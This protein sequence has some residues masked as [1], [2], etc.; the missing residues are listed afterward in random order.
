MIAEL[1]CIHNN[2]GFIQLYGKD[3]VIQWAELG[4]RTTETY[5][6]LPLLT[7]D[8]WAG[9]AAQDLWRLPSPPNPAHRRMLRADFVKTS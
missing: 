3:D 8:H 2:I 4:G 9:E 7:Q 6:L 5:V 1:I